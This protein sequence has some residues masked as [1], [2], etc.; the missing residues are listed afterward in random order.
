[1]QLS[2]ARWLNLCVPQIQSDEALHLKS[3]Y[4]QVE[5]RRAKSTPRKREG[6][7]ETLPRLLN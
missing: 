7:L 1:M 4:S 2:Q 3:Q 6:I 5:K